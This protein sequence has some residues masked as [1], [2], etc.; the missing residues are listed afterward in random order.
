MK[1]RLLVPVVVVLVVVAAVAGYFAG[2]QAM[3]A[4]QPAPK[5]ARTEITVVDSAGRYVMVP[6]PV[7]RVV[8]LT[9][10]AAEVLIAL[11]AEDTVVG[12]TNYVDRKP[13]LARVIDKPRVGT[14]FKPNIEAIIAAKPEVVITYVRWPKPEALDEKLEPLGIKVVRLDFYKLD[15]L[16]AEVRILGLMLNKTGEAERLIEFWEGVLSRIKEV[17]AEL[18]PE[19]M[20]RVYLELFRPYKAAGPG[21]GFDQ[22]LRVAGGINIFADSPVAYPKVSPESVIERNPD[23]IIKSVSIAVFQP[24]GATSASKLRELAEEICSRPG[25]GEIKAV[26]EGKVYIIS[27]TLTSGPRSIIGVCYIVK[28]LYP[29]KFGW[30][31]PEEVHKRYIEEFL[32]VDYSGIWAYPPP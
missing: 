2:M 30:L 22:V 8:A 16:F 31:D 4:K 23:A 12:V 18:K 10:D 21:S 17:V 25:W 20:A 9:T 15:R 29:E 11:G 1:M 32:R 27:S 26:R 3:V 6:W 7:K 5:P 28:W 14:C 19:Q 13:E 24:Y